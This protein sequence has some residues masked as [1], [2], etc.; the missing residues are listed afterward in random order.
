MTPDDIISDVDE[1]VLGTYARIPLT[2]KKG[3]GCWVWDYENHKFLDFTTGIAVTS[4][5][6]SHPKLLEVINSQS[7]EII[8]SSNLFYLESQAR[9]AKT[10]VE[11]SFADKVFF[12]NTGTE[13]VE[14][15]IKFAKK[16]GSKNN[17]KYK[18]IS[19]FGSFHGRTYGSLSATGT[20]KYHD[21]FEPLLEG[22]DF[23]PYGDTDA[24]RKTVSENKICAVIVEPIQ[25][26]N[27][28]IIP[29]HGYLKEI[30]NICDENDI[31]LI[32]D[33]IQV[34]MGRTGKLFAY[35][36]EGIEPDIITLAK[37]LGGGVPCGA[38]LLNNRV[39]ESITPGSHG[40]T[41]G[42]N[43]LAV[44]CA[45]ATLEI[46][47]SKDLLS[48]ISELGDYFLEMLN[49]IHAE[50]PG[51]INDV[52][53]K[54]FILGIEFNSPETAKNVITKCIENGLLTIHTAGTV[55]RILP[56]LIAGKEE[57]EFALNIIN[58]SLK[59]VLT[60]G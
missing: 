29:K 57:I 13:A 49:E 48:D 56:P 15:A 31:L 43:P 54:G 11:N 34:G 16:W 12:C 27:G 25:G 7:K 47:N 36:H 3:E 22:F 35:E 8:H 28:V 1:Y 39:A 52:R 20:Q 59:E 17:N 23:V 50:Y 44:S 41:F 45:S 38:V 4:L 5:G 6:H 10:L 18:I 46:I 14:G 21:G 51:L 19:T 58:Q 40:T 60:D 9:L 24:L 2:I 55:M 42:G 32:L 30:K 37:A 53:G 33:E 26:E